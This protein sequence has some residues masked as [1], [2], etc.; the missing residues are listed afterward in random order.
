[1][2]Y[3]DYDSSIGQAEENFFYVSMRRASMAD[4][5]EAVEEG[6]HSLRL[7]YEASAV[8]LVMAC[9]HRPSFAVILSALRAAY[10][11]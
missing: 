5:I 8:N 11:S 3:I 4:Y 9:P 10:A 6:F 1:M 2:A 7:K